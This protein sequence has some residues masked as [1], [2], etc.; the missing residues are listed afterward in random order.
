[1]AAARTGDWPEAVR[2]AERAAALEFATGRPLWHRPPYHW[3]NFMLAVEAASAQ[4][5]AG[6]R[7]SA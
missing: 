3:Q 6:A 5:G 1:M 2:H 4:A 7:A